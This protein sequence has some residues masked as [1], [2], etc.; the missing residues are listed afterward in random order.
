MATWQP[1]PSFYPSP[2]LAAKAPA[3]TIAYVAAFDPD[4]K[5]PDAIAVVDVDPQSPSYS[6]IVCTIAATEGMAR[7][8]RPTQY[9]IVAPGNTGD[10]SSVAGLSE[11]GRG[12]FG[13]ATGVR[14]PSY[15]FWKRNVRKCC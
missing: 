11:A 4:R 15:S 6:R 12:S 1:D 7:G 9:P 14:D 10:L 2:R 3:E 8:G 13:P 5:A